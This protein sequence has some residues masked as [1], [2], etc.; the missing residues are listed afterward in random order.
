MKLF[1]RSGRVVLMVALMAT[2]VLSSCGGTKK[3][4]CPNH[5]FAPTLAK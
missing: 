2:V 3:Y 5:L 1:L 4:G